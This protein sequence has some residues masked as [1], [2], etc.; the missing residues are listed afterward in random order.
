LYRFATLCIK[1][2]GRIAASV[3]IAL[4]QHKGEGAWFAQHIH[5][6]VHHFE[7][8]E[9]L[10]IEC[11]GGR[12]KGSCHLDDEDVNR[13]AQS[14]AEM[15][16][17]GMLT[18]S[19]FCRA[20]NATIFPDLIIAFKKPLSNHTAHWWMHKLGFH[21]TILQKGVYMDG[22]EHEDV[23]NYWNDI[24]LPTMAKFKSHMAHYEGEDLK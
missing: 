15:Q 21:Q 10:P 13:A 3:H 11:W 20:L 22:H 14:W 5:A 12:C 7:K 4:S 17:I 6:L 8:Y 18:S 2:L 1:R 19:R 16:K 23:I 9:Q 24:F